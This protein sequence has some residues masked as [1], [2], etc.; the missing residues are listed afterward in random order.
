MKRFFVFS[1]L[2]FSTFF[3]GSIVFSYGVSSP[4]V[5]PMTAFAPI[6]T[7]TQA[8]STTTTIPPT[9]TT[10]VVKLAPSKEVKR[11]PKFEPLFEQY[12]LLPVETFSYIAWRESRC[13]TEAINA[14]WDKNG[15]MTY[16]L[17]KNKTWD[18]G[19]LQINSSWKTVVSKICGTKWGDMSVLHDLDCNLR[20]AKYLLDNGGLA[21]WGMSEN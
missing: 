20:V 13:R 1:L 7:T 15:N 6:V 3:L 21:H 16:H 11:C 19:L 4:Q 14:T 2:F 17:N 10:M 12:G 9:T 8:P 5:L 18:S